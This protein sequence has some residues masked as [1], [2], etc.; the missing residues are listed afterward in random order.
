MV[1]KASGFMIPVNDF[2]EDVCNNRSVEEPLAVF[3]MKV[4]LRTEVL[5][6]FCYT[7]NTSSN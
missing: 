3:E 1:G 2:S 4:S 7:C 6:L 5:I